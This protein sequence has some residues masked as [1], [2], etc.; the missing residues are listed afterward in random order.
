MYLRASDE[1]GSSLSQVL[2][3]LQTVFGCFGD[4]L[5]NAVAC[6]SIWDI[7]LEPWDQTLMPWCFFLHRMIKNGQEVYKQTKCVP[8]QFL[9]LITY[10]D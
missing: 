3:V 6:L 4:R 5:P 8:S 10:L 7:S 1:Q 9:K 2:L